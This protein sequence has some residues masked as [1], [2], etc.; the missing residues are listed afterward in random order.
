MKDLE[1]RLRTVV[2]M[3]QRDT[4]MDPEDADLI[5]SAFQQAVALDPKDDCTPERVGM[6]VGGWPTSWTAPKTSAT[7]SRCVGTLPRFFRVS[8]PSRSTRAGARNAGLY[9]CGLE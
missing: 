2:N 1:R 7:A 8:Q 3:A 5:R 4:G 6:L 9:A